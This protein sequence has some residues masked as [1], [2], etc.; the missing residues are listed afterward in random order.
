MGGAC[1]KILI[2]DDSPANVMVIRAVAERLG[3][4]VVQARDGRE[5]VRLYQSE[6]PDLIFMDVM[7]PEMDG[8]AA[9]RQIR[10][11]PSERWVPLVFCS[12]LDRKEEVIQGLECGGDD[13][14]TKPVD[15]RLLRAKINGYAHALAMQRE[16]YAQAQSLQAWQAQ[17]EEQALLGS[18]IMARLTDMPGLRDPMLRHFNLPADKFSGDLLCAARTPG[19]VLHVMLADATGHGLPAALSALPLTQV[20][21]GMT[22]KG[23]PL[24]SI[25]EELN[26]KLKRLMPAD[27][28]VAATLAAIDVRN[29]IIEIW[30]GGNPEALFL[31]ERGEI[32][33]RWPSRHPPLGILPEE[34]FSGETQSVRIGE[35]GDL[36]IFSDGLVEAESSDGRRL[37]PE[38]IVD[39]LCRLEAGQRYSGLVSGLETH[40][41]GG[42]AQDDISFM[43]VHVP[44]ERRQS[45]RSTMAERTGEE[46]VS[47]WSMHLTYGPA[48]LRSQDVVP[49]VLDMLLRIGIVRPHRGALF[50]I[51]SELFNNALD[52]GLLGLD[53]AVKEKADG[54]ELFLQQ[55]ARRLAGL[56]E[57]R[58]ELGFRVHLHEGRPVLDIVVEDSGKGFDYLP[59][60]S[61]TPMDRG[62]GP[63]GRGIAL[64]RSLCE[65]MAYSGGGSRVA[66]RYRL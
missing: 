53:S 51:V 3:H 7:M 32:A 22:A 49:A 38:A 61:Q 45:V 20:F 66:V 13:Y 39:R 9:T 35:P 24:P 41:A 16:M 12:A 25:V 18:H 57:G 1:L 60:Q 42:Q 56:S 17:A 28:F 47:E 62:D 65:E 2:A 37:T 29:Q 14:L 52:H 58:I 46:A 8:L 63:H 33:M 15:L 21:Y 34:G 55:R 6:R 40:L 36:L 43:L 5:A 59:Y 50:L 54:F 4:I 26:R 27:R 44:L 11:L 23:F 31:S 64:V 19:G 30:N 48:E 10:A